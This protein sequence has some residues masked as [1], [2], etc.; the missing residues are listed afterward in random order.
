[1]KVQYILIA[2]LLIAIIL[3]SGCAKQSENTGTSTE[4]EATPAT[5]A[6]KEVVKTNCDDNNPCTTD[7][8]NELTNQCEHEVKE[9]CCGN[10]KCETGERCNEATHKTDCVADCGRTCPA[11][12]VISSTEGA[13]ESEVSALQC[14]GDN[15]E[16][17]DANSFRITGNSAIS[18]NIFN[19]GEYASSTIT[20]NFYCSGD[21]VSATKDRQGIRGVIFKDYFDNNLESLSSL[22]GAH[23]EFNSGTYYMNFNTTD[24]EKDFDATCKIYIQE[25]DFKN[26]Q[27]I[28]LSFRK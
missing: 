21:G 23:T 25:T 1:M 16:K 9:T 19:L 11:F 12:L 27:S 28:K 17:I 2:T 22:S 20:S 4:K 13:A 10:G 8:Y 26:T 6:E 3:F 7:I 15:C 18:T 14:S 24:I 5:P